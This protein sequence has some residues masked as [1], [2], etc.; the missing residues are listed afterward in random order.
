M[1]E[2]LIF[3]PGYTTSDIQEM[4]ADAVNALVKH[5]FKEREVLTFLLLNLF[6]YTVHFTS[7]SLVTADILENVCYVWHPMFPVVS[8]TLTLHHKLR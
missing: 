3:I 4:V 6:F 8:E 1:S 7:I 2:H 5:L